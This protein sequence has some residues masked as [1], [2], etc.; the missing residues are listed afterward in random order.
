MVWLTGHSTVISLTVALFFVTVAGENRVSADSAKPGTVRVAGIVLKW[1]RGDKAANYRRAEPMIREA[2]A[3]GAKIVC[4]TECFLD[5]YAI[6]DKNIPLTTYRALGEPIP[7]GPYYRRLARLAGDLKILLVAGMLE[8]DGEH[9]CNTAA[10][11]APD[12]QLIGTYRK[13]FLEHESVRNTAGTV[14]SV[15]ATPFGRLGVMICADRRDPAIVRRFCES[16]A[17]SVSY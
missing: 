13:Q 12:G 17:K 14:S 3:A 11:I 9:R 7:A 4:T 2:A 16:G 6:A 5:G 10:I 8:A 1:I 15:H